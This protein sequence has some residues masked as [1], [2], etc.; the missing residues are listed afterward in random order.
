MV[1]SKD[2]TTG[3]KPSSL[4]THSKERIFNPVEAKIGKRSASPSQWAPDEDKVGRVLYSKERCPPVAFF[5]HRVAGQ[6]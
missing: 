6:I 4:T 2:T 3:P 1:A 5:P